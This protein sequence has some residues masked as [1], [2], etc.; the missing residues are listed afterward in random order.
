L[1]PSLGRDTSGSAANPVVPTGSGKVRGVTLNSVHAFKGIPYGAPTGGA[2]RFLP[3][4]KPQLWSDVRDALE[5]GHRAPQGPSTLIPEVAAMDRREPAGEDCL[6]LNVW[7]SGL[8]DGAK[9]PVM[10]WLHGGGYTGASGSYIMYDG[11][12]LARKHDVVVV[13]LNHRLNVFGYLYLVELGGAKYANAANVGMLDIVAALQWV[14]DNIVAFGGDPRNVTI[15]GQSGGGGKVSTLLAM[16]AATGLFHRAIAES[17]SAVRGIPRLEATK[18]AEDFLSRLGL[19]SN[20]VDEL[21][22]LP[23]DQL[24]KD[25]VQGGGAGNAPLP[26]GPVVDGR[27]LPANPFDPSAPEISAGVPLLTGTVETEVTFVPNQQLDPIDDANLHARVKQA[28]AVDDAAADR[29]IAAYR[30]GRPN[31]SNIDLYLILASDRGFR[32]DV[33]TQA[34]RKADQGKAPVYMYYFTWRSPV[35]DGKLKAFHTLEIPFVFDNL[36]LDAAMTGSGQD[37]FALGEKMSAAWVA[38]ARTGNPNHAGLPPWAPFKT[39]QRATMIF[40]NQCKVVNDP[41][42]AERLALRAVQS[43]T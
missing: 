42:G 23:A 39:A 7:S 27:T 38:F 34:E 41:N 29:L 40:D 30:K 16:P 8:G 32:T 12:N 10:V 3:P 14:R 21:Q 4:L 28:V 43:A 13:T 20:Q 25:I 35:R 24:V 19:K 15:F 31:I 18:A 1:V 2:R 11:S 26:L 37:R 36:E 33:L 6:V 5:F 22:E 9:R 17:G